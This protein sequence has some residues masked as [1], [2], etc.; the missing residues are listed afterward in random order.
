MISDNLK[1]NNFGRHNHVTSRCFLKDKK[2]AR[3]NQFSARHESQWFS[4]KGAHSSGMS[5]A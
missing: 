4:G 1:R 3:I 5:K 2:D